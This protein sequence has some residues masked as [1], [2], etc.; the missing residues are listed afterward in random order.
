MTDYR[1]R[2]TDG[3]I[4][5][6][7]AV[8][9]DGNG[10][11]ARGRGLSRSEGHEAGAAVIEPLMDTVQELGIEVVSLYAFST[12]NWMRPSSEVSGL[13]KLLQKF[14]S[15]KLDTMKEK[16]IRVMHSGSMKKLPSGVQKAIGNAV[17]ESA[18]N[19]GPVL[20]FCINYGS[21]EEII[22]AVNRWM[23]DRGKRDGIT[24]KDIEKYLYTSSLPDVDL[25]VR[26]S[27][28]YRISNFLLWQS[29]YAELVFLDVLWPDFTAEHLYQAIY[30][31]Q[32][33]DRRFGGL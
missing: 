24:E 21:R 16:G 23:K 27:G 5:R 17:E 33:R 6:H 8:I 1:A 12:E 3:P 26:T 9:M 7:V 31:Y 2:I 30:S 32:Q 25:L 28:E 20:N 10:R 11:W 22:Q 29:A 4:P 14:F 13:W 19:S 18:Q 15:E